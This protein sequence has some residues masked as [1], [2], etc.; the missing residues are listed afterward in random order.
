MQA[1]VLDVRKKADGADRLQHDLRNG[2]LTR[3]GETG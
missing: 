1:L 3:T 2:R